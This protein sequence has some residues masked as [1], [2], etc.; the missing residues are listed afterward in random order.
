MSNPAAALHPCARCAQVQKT[1]CQR[2][3]ILV[4]DGDVARITAHTGRRDFAAFRAPSD[5]DYLVTDPGDP[6]WVGWTIRADGTRHVLH[7]QANGDCTFLG[8]QGCVLPEATRPLVCRLYPYNYTERGLIVESSHYCPTALLAPRGEP[9]ADVLGMNAVDAE[10]WRKQLY[11][12]LRADAA[13]RATP[14]HAMATPL[15]VGI[16]YDL[17]QDYQGLGFSEEELA[18]LDKP[19]T[20]EAIEGA[21]RALGHRPVRIGNLTKLLAALQRGERWDLVFNIAEGLRGIGREAQVPAVL[22]AYGIPYTF[23]D[24]LVCAL[25]LHKGMTKRVVRDLGV[26]TAAFCEVAALADVER[27]DLR[28]PLFAKPIAE[29]TSKGIDPS[30][31]LRNREELRQACARLLAQYRQPVLVEEFL[32]G[33]EVTV[34]LAGTGAEA[35]VLAVM[36]VHLQKGADA[37]IYTYRNKEQYETLVKYA[38]ATDDF[39]KQAGEVALQAW[40]GL[41]CRDGGRVDL[42]ADAEG[43]I[44]FIEVNPLAGLNPKTSDLPIMCRLAGISYVDLLG[45]IVASARARV[46]AR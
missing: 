7:K 45:A 10:R 31:K 36:E 33:R 8:E 29:G 42:R 41:G 15:T 30:S 34:G 23:S 14:H 4:T 38:L 44:C 28:F 18:E 25:T 21:L 46:V 2:A 22:D 32:P 9:M 17:K 20:I 43:R 6:N 1:C 13:R 39:A 5:P 37:E 11:D 3:E 24:P 35:R 16:T 19:E 40:R 27:V 26:P 12:E